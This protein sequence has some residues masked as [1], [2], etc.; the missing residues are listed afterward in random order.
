MSSVLQCPVG[1]NGDGVDV[2]EP[3]AVQPTC[4]TGRNSIKN[5]LK[6]RT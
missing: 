4:K 5:E 2:C 3:A 1:F 6:G